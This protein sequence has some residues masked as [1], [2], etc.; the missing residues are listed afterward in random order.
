MSPWRGGFKAFTG[1]ENLPQAMVNF[2][3]EVVNLSVAADW[4]RDFWL[5]LADT[6]NLIFRRETSRNDFL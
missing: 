2:P 5:N 4:Q 3:R 6:D 1:V